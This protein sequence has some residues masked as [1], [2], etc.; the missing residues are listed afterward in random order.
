MGLQVIDAR[1]GFLTYPGLIIDI[2]GNQSSAVQLR[3]LF[4]SVPAGLLMGFF[5]DYTNDRELYQLP[6]TA[7]AKGSVYRLW[8]DGTRLTWAGDA[9]AIALVAGANARDPVATDAGT[10]AFNPRLT[11]TLFTPGDQFVTQLGTV[12]G[13]QYYRLNDQWPWDIHTAEVLASAAMLSPNQQGVLR[14]SLNI[15]YSFR[16]ALVDGNVA[17][18]LQQPGDVVRWL[19]PS[20]GADYRHPR[21]LLYIDGATVAATFQQETAGAIDYTKPCIIRVFDT[22]TSSWTVKWEDTLPGSAHVAAYDPI[23][24]LVYA[25]GRY[26]SQTTVWAA[27]LA[28]APAAVAVPTLVGATTLAELTATR[29][30]TLV[31][32]ARGSAISQYLVQWALS[33]SL[34]GGALNSAYSLTNNSGIATIVYVGP[35]RPP[36]G[37]TERVTATV[38]DVAG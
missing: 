26:A 8:R 4:Y 32:D 13:D 30:S 17:R 12:S 23:N 9:T 10:I 6:P 3:K 21:D 31:T 20:N 34:S 16:M 5:V 19:S 14:P 37:L 35:R 22:T 25:A 7:N 33:A 1:S 36:A 28:R 24:K 15:A 27:R 29:L 2:F 18:I 11:G 38:S